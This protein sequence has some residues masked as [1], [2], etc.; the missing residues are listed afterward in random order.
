MK[1][2][3]TTVATPTGVT[4]RTNVA[5]TYGGNNADAAASASSS[6]QVDLS[7]ASQ[8]MAALQNDSNDI[9]TNRVQAIRDAIASG[10]YTINPSGI[11][12][13]LIASIQ[14]LLR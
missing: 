10:Q 9:D 4:T 11:T 3:T 2:T 1:I 12:D 5:R 14:E 13:G 8:Q 6:S 7:P